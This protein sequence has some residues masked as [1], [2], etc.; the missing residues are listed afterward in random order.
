MQKIATLVAKR[1]LD[2]HSIRSTKMKVAIKDNQILTAVDLQDKTLSS[3]GK[4]FLVGTG[5]ATIEHKGETV[6]VTVQATIKNPD[7]KKPA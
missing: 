7:Y 1:E 6:K 2:S 3:T 5:Y 4:T